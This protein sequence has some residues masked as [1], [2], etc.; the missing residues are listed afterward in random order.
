VRLL[1]EA[2]VEYVCDWPNDEQPYRMTVPVGTMI[3]LPVTLD[4]D[5]VFTHRERGVSM[6][7]W[8]RLVT[9]AFDGLYEDGAESGRLI[10]MNVHP[11]LIGQPFRIKY[12]DE[13][14]THILRRQGV[15]SATAGEI[16]DWYA[17]ASAGQ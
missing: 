7:R 10:V 9:E 8:L 17:Q 5:E 12:L 3:S 4:L 6:P 16:V 14:L 11:Y 1:A 15:W 2:G 13:A